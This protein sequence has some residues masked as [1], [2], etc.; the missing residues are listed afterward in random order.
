MLWLLCNRSFR[1]FLCVLGVTERS[2]VVYVYFIYEHLAM[3]KTSEKNSGYPLF[4][5]SIVIACLLVLTNLDWFIIHLCDLI[6]MI[7][8]CLLINITFL[9]NMDFKTFY[10]LQ[11]HR[12]ETCTFKK[13]CFFSLNALFL[14]FSGDSLIYHTG[15]LFSTWDRDNDD[16][17]DCSRSYYG[18]WW[19]NSC[20][21]SN[22]NGKY[23][24]PG[25]FNDISM[26]WKWASNGESLKSTRMMI[27]PISFWI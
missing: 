19:Y 1:D 13:K 27:R 5:T 11:F 12:E 21:M 17:S 15:S 26:N 10:F 4:P 16:G 22:L 25:V 14:L 9:Q 6:I 2:H 24:G 3:H 20:Y 7:S 18:A 8:R 23:M